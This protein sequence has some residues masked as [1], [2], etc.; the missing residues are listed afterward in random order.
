MANTEIE[1]LLLRLETQILNNQS[2][3]EPKLYEQCINAIQQHSLPQELS[4]KEIELRKKDMELRDLVLKAKNDLQR[5]K[6]TLIHL[7]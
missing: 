5:I 1:S 2:V 6:N 3:I 4:D 7:I